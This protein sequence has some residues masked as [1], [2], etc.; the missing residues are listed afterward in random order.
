MSRAV[1]E[2]PGLAMRPAG[3]WCTERSSSPRW[4]PDEGNEPPPDPAPVTGHAPPVADAAGDGQGGDG[5]G[6]DAPGDPPASPGGSA[7]RSGPGWRIRKGAYESLAGAFRLRPAEGWRLLVGDQ[8]AKVEALGEA[9][10]FHADPEILLRV[11]GRR[12]SDV[13]LAAYQREQVA[14]MTGDYDLQA[15]LAGFDFRKAPEPVLREPGRLRD[16]R[17]G[18]DLDVSALHMEVVEEPRLAGSRG[19]GTMVRAG[20][21]RRG[22]VVSASSTMNDLDDGVFEAQRKAFAGALPGAIRETRTIEQV[23]L[24]GLASRTYHWT[25]PQACWALTLARRG[26]MLY[27]VSVWQEPPGPAAVEDQLRSAFHLIE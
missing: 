7:R 13:S 11:D 15:L 12:A 22:I 18:F 23:R 19:F 14:T 26:R 25:S 27:V 20:D 3:P 24:A 16:A 5:Q 4:S 2:A 21:G 6:G 10:I 8:L 17:F 9:G 1:R